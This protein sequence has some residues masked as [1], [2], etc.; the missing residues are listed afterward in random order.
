MGFLENVFWAAPYILFSGGGGVGIKHERWSRRHQSW[1][2][3]SQTTYFDALPLLFLPKNKMSF[4]SFN[5]LVWAIRYN[6]FCSSL[7]AI[8]TGSS[9]R[10][11]RP[12]RV[13]VLCSNPA[14]KKGT[15]GKGLREK[16]QESP[17]PAP[18]FWAT[19]ISKVSL[20]QRTS[21]I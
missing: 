6:H 2:T 5:S 19:V 14:L 15:R 17:V 4:I 9:M 16:R 13:D 12:A 11:S 3:S 10:N 21:L 8:C 1:K 7:F 18:P 20:R